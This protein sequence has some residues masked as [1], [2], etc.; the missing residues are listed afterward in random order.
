MK[1]ENADFD[2]VHQNLEDIQL[3]SDLDIIQS[4][5][6]K[7]LTKKSHVLFLA[8]EKLE[9]FVVKMLKNHDFVRHCV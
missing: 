7:M 5:L 2:R 1:N 4:D 8:N 9:I 3:H 6:L